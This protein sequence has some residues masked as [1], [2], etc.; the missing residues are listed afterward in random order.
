MKLQQNVFQNQLQI[1]YKKFNH[2]Y[3]YIINFENN[4][5]EI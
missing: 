1:L 5:I 2:F 3:Y 4:I